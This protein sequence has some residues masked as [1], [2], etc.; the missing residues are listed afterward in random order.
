MATSPEELYTFTNEW[1]SSY[2][3]ISLLVTTVFDEFGICNTTDFDLVFEDEALDAFRQLCQLVLGFNSDWTSFIFAMLFSASSTVYNDIDFVNRLATNDNRINALQNTDLLVQTAIAPTLRVRNVDDNNTFPLIKEDTIIYMGPKDDPN[4]AIYTTTLGAAYIINSTWNGFVY[5]SNK[6]LEDYALYVGVTPQEHDFDDWTLFGLWDTT[7]E[8]GG[9]ALVPLEDLDDNEDISFMDGI[10][11][12]SPFGGNDATGVVQVA[13]ISSAAAATLS[14]GSPSVFTQVLSQSR[15]RIRD[16]LGIL[17]RGIFDRA[18]DRFYNTPL[19]DNIAV[20]SQWPDDCT[21]FDRYF[22]DGGVVENAALAINIAQYQQSLGDTVSVSRQNDDDDEIMKLILT[23]TNTYWPKESN[24]A[25]LLPYFATDFNQDIP[26]GEFLSLERRS[27]PIRSPQIFAEYYNE[28]TLTEVLIPIDDSNI[29]TAILTLTTIDNPAYGV[30]GGLEFELMLINLNTNIT[31]FVAGPLIIE[32]TTE[33]H[34]EMVQHIA[35][36]EILLER[37]KQFYSPPSQVI[38]TDTI[39]QTTD[40]PPTDFFTD[41]PPTDMN[42]DPLPTDFFTDFPPTDMNTDPLP[43]DFFTDVP[44]TDMNTDPTDFFT[45]PPPMDEFTDA[46]EAMT[47]P[48]PT[49]FITDPPPTDLFTDPTSFNDSGCWP[50]IEVQHCKVHC[51]I[52]FA[53]PGNQAI[54][55]ECRDTCHTKLCRDPVPLPAEDMINP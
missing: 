37:V 18:V 50:D 43:T 40:S 26:P 3:N 36:N 10:M 48:V 17:A 12:Q 34:A 35:S 7:Y 39:P 31:T 53:G 49:D 2:Y 33:P 25:Q 16:E 11:I 8:S 46:T 4:N 29:T 21:E 20:C 5:E 6:Q 38:P 22:L 44:P 47:D 51:D 1:M 24:L 28:E 9:R 54:K 45:D 23:N 42:T 19:I 14:P 15:Q 32:A 55:Q 52:D 30:Q 41:M 13:A 27:V